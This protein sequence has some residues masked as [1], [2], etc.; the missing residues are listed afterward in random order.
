MPGSSWVSHGSAAPRPYQAPGTGPR[1][2]SAVPDHSP[3]HRT[4]P[5]RRPHHRVRRPRPEGPGRTWGHHI[6]SRHRRGG[7]RRPGRRHRGRRCSRVRSPCPAGERLPVDRRFLLRADGVEPD[8]QLWKPER[9]PVGA[10]VGCG[11]P[12]RQVEPQQ[13]QTVE[14]HRPPRVQRAT[15]R[16]LD[17]VVRHSRSSSP[18][19]M[20]FPDVTTQRLA[21]CVDPTSEFTRTRHPPRSPHMAQAADSK[22]CAAHPS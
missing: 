4:A 15:E 7:R 21:C 1:D 16:H 8:S 13:T 14:E 22:S 3:G 17:D 11:E 9:G 10:A 2:S 19:Q 20:N 12:L 18:T 5:S 6:R